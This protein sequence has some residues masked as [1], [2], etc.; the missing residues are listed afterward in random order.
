MLFS[1]I[2]PTFNRAQFIRATLNSVRA[3]EFKDYEVIAVDDGST[4]ETISILRG[5]PW[6]R[7][8]QQ[9]H[10]GPGVARNYGVGQASGEYIAFL[11]S[12]DIWFPWTLQT[13]ADLLFNQDH[14]DLI[15]A[16]LFE[17]FNDRELERI[18][19]ENLKIEVFPDYYASSRKCYFVG[20]CMMVIRRKVFLETGGFSNEPVYAEDCDLA[21]RLGLV[22]GFVQIL[23]PITLGYRQHSSNARRDYGRIYRGTVQL[24]ESERG[25]KYP[26]GEARKFDRVRLVTLHTRPFSL[27]CVKHEYHR[28]G[29]TLYWKT[30]LWHVRMLR[31]K[32]LLGFPVLAVWHAIRRGRGDHALAQPAEQLP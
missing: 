24:V 23:S 15:A 19:R 16:R 14:P 10:K 2:I 25:G 17:F 3:Q 8:F 29:W 13:F 1:I 5:C 22:R 6:I 4:D 18:S 7:V 27:A 30:I 31:W 11:D 12:D 28:A 26:G 21:L 32:Y 9:D 20:A